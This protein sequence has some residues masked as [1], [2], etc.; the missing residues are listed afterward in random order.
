LFLKKQREMDR[1]IGEEGKSVWDVKRLWKRVV[2][3]ERK[4]EEEE[5]GLLKRRRFGAREMKGLVL[6]A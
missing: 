4:K 5:K 1:D 3:G 6:R 2:G